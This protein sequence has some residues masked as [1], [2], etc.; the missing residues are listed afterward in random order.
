MQKIIKTNKLMQSNAMVLSLSLKLHLQYQQYIKSCICT[1]DS[2]CKYNETGRLFNYHKYIV[3]R[4]KDTEKYENRLR[5][6]QL[7]QKKK[8]FRKF[9]HS[10]DCKFTVIEWFIYIY[11]LLCF[12][13]SMNHISNSVLFYKNKPNCVLVKRTEQERNAVL[14]LFPSES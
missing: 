14:L 2:A 8:Y 6:I 5:K 4:L 9:T 3:M 1:L 7:L 11:I 12:K 10:T 13:Y